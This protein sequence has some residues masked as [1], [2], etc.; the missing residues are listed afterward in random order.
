MAVRWKLLTPMNTAQAL[1]SL[2]SVAADDDDH[3]HHDYNAA[4]F[5]VA[6]YNFQVSEIS[7]QSYFTKFIIINL[8]IPLLSTGR[9]TYLK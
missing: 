6:S 3:H 8:C 9:Y 7:A 1:N 5:E 4:N 2:H